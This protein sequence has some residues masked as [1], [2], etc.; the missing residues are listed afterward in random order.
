[1][2]DVPEDFIIAEAALTAF[3][4]TVSDVSKILSGDPANFIIRVAGDHQRIYLRK[5]YL[6]ATYSLKSDLKRPS[7]EVLKVLGM[8]LADIVRSTVAA[9]AG[10]LGTYLATS[11]V[12]SERSKNIRFENTSDMRI[13]FEHVRN[14]MASEFAEYF[15]DART[16]YWTYR[17]SS[18]F[19]NE[20]VLQEHYQNAL[21][22]V[23]VW[24]NL[25][26]DVR[27]RIYQRNI[28]KINDRLLPSRF[29]FAVLD[30]IYKDKIETYDKLEAYR[31]SRFHRNLRTLNSRL[32]EKSGIFRVLN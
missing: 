10:G 22:A 17:S 6:R 32:R 5:S 28:R 8:E 13:H 27:H 18:L 16:A 12:S 9:T 7:K 25:E 4:M 21:E 30:I 15:N 11:H 24:L 3:E 20:T 31:A 2:A 14:Q 29:K 23:A 1:M 19:T 26:V